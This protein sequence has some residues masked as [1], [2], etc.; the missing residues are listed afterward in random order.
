MK[1]HEI[2]GILIGTFTILQEGAME[3]S[4]AELVFPTFGGRTLMRS[5]FPNSV[6]F[7]SNGF[8]QPCAVIKNT[9]SLLCGDG[10]GDCTD[11]SKLT[12]TIHWRK[13]LSGLSLM[14]VTVKKWLWLFRVAFMGCCC[15]P[16]TPFTE[17][18]VHICQLR[19]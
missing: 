9:L 4:M 3:D 17:T 8:I 11:I 14:T 2:E 12:E 18:L 15:L 6:K 10:M 16:H 7:R 1:T 13:E 5:S 19:P